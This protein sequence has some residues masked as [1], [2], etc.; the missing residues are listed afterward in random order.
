MVKLDPNSKSYQDAVR[1]NV[2]LIR[3]CE[4]NKPREREF[5][6]AVKLTGLQKEMD[7]PKPNLSW[8]AQQLRSGSVRGDDPF[9]SVYRRTLL[10]LMVIAG[11]VEMV[12]LC[13]AHG[14]D[15]K[16]RDC[17]GLLPFHLAIVH[18]HLKMLQNMLPVMRAFG[19]SVHTPEN[20]AGLSP[21]HLACI[22]NRP[23]IL[24]WL[25]DHGA[26]VDDKDD[27]GALPLHKAAFVGSLGCVQ[28]LVNRRAFVKAEDIDGNTPLLLAMKEVIFFV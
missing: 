20:A 21:V 4:E 11:D 16:K 22:F 7:Q 5:N 9:E 17:F 13:L 8:I 2:L 19:Q 6:A 3:K 27:Y 28:A 15:P 12:E 14:A 18:G 1:H 24:E 25:L 26:E 23:K 10:H